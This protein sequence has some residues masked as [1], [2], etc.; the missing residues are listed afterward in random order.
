MKTKLIFTLFLTLCTFSQSAFAAFIL[1]GTRFIYDEGRKNI[2]FEISNESKET[3][4]GQVWIDNVLIPKEDVAFVP[5]PSF[6]KVEGGQT[7]VVRIMKI[8]DKLPKDKES[9]FWLNVQEIPPVN[10]DQNNVMVVA[11]NTQVKLLYRPAGIIKGRNNAESKML[12]KKEGTSYILNNPTPYYFA[13]TEFKVNGK[14]VPLSKEL[15][16]KLGMISPQSSILLNGVKLTPTSKVVVEAID[17]YGAIN[18][19][20]VINNAK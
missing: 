11:V 3:Y 19:Y 4:G 20:E 12:L 1:N 7:Q 8:T 10:K 2:S 18:K 17:D 14:A 16:N 15:S 6:F 13:V 9:I 5:M